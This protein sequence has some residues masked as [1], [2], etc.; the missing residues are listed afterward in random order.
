MGWCLDCGAKT[1]GRG[2]YCST[3]KEKRERQKTP[4]VPLTEQ[5]K[6]NLEMLRTVYDPGYA[7][8]KYFREV[9]NSIQ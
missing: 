4:F 8:D 6:E 2:K 3:H 5:E 1:N 7:V 9:Q